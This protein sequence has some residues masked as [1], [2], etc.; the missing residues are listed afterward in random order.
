[1][2]RHLP[3]SNNQ[4][5]NKPHTMHWL[6]INQLPLFFWFETGA[7]IFSLF[8]LK[9]K[10]NDILKLFIPFLLL[11][12]GAELFGLYLA[13]MYRNNLWWFNFF[14]SF[15]FI[16]YSIIF[17]FHYSKEK[18]KNT[19]RFFIPFYIISLAVNF[20]FFQPVL[21]QF[22]SHTMLIGSFF[23]ILFCCFYFLELFG[24]DI[25]F[26]QQPL[27]WIAC[28]LLLFYLGNFFYNL[29]LDY[30]VK[31]KLDK[32]RIM[33]VTINNNLNIIMYSFFSIG[34]YV[35]GRK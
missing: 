10:E 8:L 24:R 28:G 12:L 27:F 29:L 25:N 5:I 1:M 35:A 11:T 2:S 30:L 3:V 13:K 23:M 17:Y 26:L 34:F 21:K 14:T 31:Y 18:Y 7:F 16:F 9:R 22:H 19:V 33:F 6:K 20:I 15:E 32:E 4:L